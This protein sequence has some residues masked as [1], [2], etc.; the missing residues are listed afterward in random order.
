[1]G[2][3]KTATNGRGI[4]AADQV[5]SI[6]KNGTAWAQKHAGVDNNELIEQN[7]IDGMFLYTYG[8]TN[9]YGLPVV[10]QMTRKV[11]QNGV[12]NTYNTSFNNH[13]VTG[14]PLIQLTHSAHRTCT[15]TAAPP[16]PRSRC[17]PQ[18]APSAPPDATSPTA[19]RS[20]PKACPPR[21]TTKTPTTSAVPG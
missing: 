11:G 8:R 17:S 14:Q 16:A 6:T 18:T 1:M 10:E 13:P 5:S 19:S 7:S 4:T 15:S 2:R 21:P 3:L 9:D 20:S 12:N